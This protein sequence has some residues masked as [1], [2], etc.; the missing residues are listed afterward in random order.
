LLISSPYGDE[1]NSSH[2]YTL[3]GKEAFEKET[4]KKSRTSMIWWAFLSYRCTLIPV[5]N[6]TRALTTNL[7]MKLKL[8]LSLFFYPAFF[9]WL[10]RKPRLV[11]S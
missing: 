1:R 3:R 7:T 5:N 8:F 2:E 10:K 9:D 11:K 4:P 6:Q